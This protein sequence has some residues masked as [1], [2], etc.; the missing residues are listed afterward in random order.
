LFDQENLR[1]IY[2]FVAENE[3]KRNEWGKN[4]G[5]DNDTSRIEFYLDKLKNV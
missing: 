3:I 1:G 5:L 4:K 2:R